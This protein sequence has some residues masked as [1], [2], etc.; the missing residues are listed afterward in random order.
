MN[1]IMKHYK[2][3]IVLLP[4][5]MMALAVVSCGKDGP[6]IDVPE[7]VTPTP[8]PQ[9]EPTVNYTDGFNY[10]V[11]TLDA[12]RPVTITYKAPSGSSLYGASGDMYLYSG[13]GVNWEG[14]PAAWT[15][16]QAKYKMTPVSGQSN[17]WSITLSGSIRGFYGL[18][19]TT[20]V[21]LL[22]LIVRTADGSKQTGDYTVLVQDARSGFTLTQPEKAAVP[23]GGSEIEGIHLQSSASAT[24]VL[25][26]RDTKGKR[27][28][29]VYVLGSMN[30]WSLKSDY[31][32]KYDE[33][34][35]C[36]WIT[37]T[38]L[39]PGINLFQYFAYSA[40]DGGVFVCEPYSEQVLERDVN[41]DF[42]S[43]AGGR[44]VSVLQTMPETYHWKVSDFK[45]QHPDNLVIYE[46]LLRDFTTSHNLD[47]ALQKLPY[48]KAMGVNAIELMPVQEFEGGDS[49]GYNT[50]FYF[51]L[52]NSYGTQ[53][54]YKEFID[55]CHQ[56][57]M[58]VI[59]DVV[60]NHT[61]RYNPFSSLYWDVY[62][63]R[64]SATNPWLNAVTPHGK[65]VFS[66]ADFNHESE[67]TQR[68]VKRNLKFL[69]D[70]YHLDGFRFDFTKGFTQKKTTGDDDLSAYDAARVKVL[71][72]YSEA[73]KAVKSD[74]VIIME[75]FAASEESALS[76]EGINFWR[77]ANY[78]YMQS[79]MGWSESS[80]FAGAYDASMRFVSFMESH[81]E[82][83]MGYKQRKWG[84][85]ELQTNL[86]ARMK[87]LATNA[88]FF[89]TV[90]GPKMI[91][92]FGELGY[93]FSINSN[94]SGAEGQEYRTARKPVRWD[95]YDQAERKGLYDAYCKLMALRN[96]HPELFGQGAF[97]EWRVSGSDWDAGR[98][99]KLE[100]TT[101]KLIVV[102]NFTAAD[103]K[104]SANFGSTGTWYGLD[105]DE[106]QVTSAT[107]QVAVPSHEYKLYTNFK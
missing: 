81:D 93:D 10:D 19:T 71:Q 44:Y 83:R 57:G 94:E 86:G 17:V 40:A 52:D 42:P 49:W 102:G 45:V 5:W 55:A 68:F 64:P 26:D 53:T 104:V 82:E 95:Y 41:T 74:A 54:R 9:P 35:G 22:N 88:A 25:Y 30:G 33:T 38:G 24:L 13:V 63:N 97:K 90:P 96:A 50:S 69:L 62:N 43:K 99:L 66:P 56:A 72:T 12:D 1:E 46:M 31:Q 14:K 73:V 37:L 4:L 2:Q 65:Y 85:G 84:N 98:Y 60:Y 11:Q 47:G 51:A 75:H 87:Q 100:S 92:Q 78:A 39:N 59:L 106:L 89:L 58:A 79:A 77:N 76:K 6:E 7:P 18:S 36:W 105:G 34:T 67:L 28:D 8:Q 20:P 3:L 29:H 27:K 15:D 16:N 61:N 32:M 103:V 70:T 107:Q 23:V 80:S 91:W 101:K 21:Q 48:L